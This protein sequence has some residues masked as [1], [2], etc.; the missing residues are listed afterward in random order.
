MHRPLPG[1]SA[2]PSSV[3]HSGRAGD[4]ACPRRDRFFKDV[5]EAI[6]PRW[7]FSLQQI[8]SDLLEIME[9]MGGGIV[10]LHK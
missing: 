10:A 6:P 1:L 8:A 3:T 2:V 9:R 4:P 5:I 7:R